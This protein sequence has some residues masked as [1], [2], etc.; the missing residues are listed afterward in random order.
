MG[1]GEAGHISSANNRDV[2]A[3]FRGPLPPLVQNTPPTHFRLSL[4]L[5]FMFS[6]RFTPARAIPLSS[7]MP[8]PSTSSHATHDPPKPIHFQAGHPGSSS[9]A[10][11]DPY[12]AARRPTS[13]SAPAGSSSQKTGIS[14]SRDYAYVQP[15]LIA[16]QGGSA[17]ENRLSL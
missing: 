8:S 11:F 2:S 17:S 14:R 7:V 16:F 5:S 12:A 3:V 13:I 9:I 15:Y 6:L 1:E 10:H 4:V